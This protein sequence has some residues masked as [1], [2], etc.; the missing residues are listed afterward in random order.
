MCVCVCVCESL[1]KPQ[2]AFHKAMPAELEVR[3]TSGNLVLRKREDPGNEVGGAARRPWNT[4][5]RT[6]P[7]NTEVFLCGS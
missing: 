2:A 6:V 4:R 7:T 1:S 3:A 5:L